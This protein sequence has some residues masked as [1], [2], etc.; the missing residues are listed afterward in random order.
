M[1]Y[2]RKERSSTKTGT[3]ITLS[4]LLVAFVVLKLCGVIDWSWW[5]VT[6]PIWIP[7]GI[8]LLLFAVSGMMILLEKR[9]RKEK[10][11]ED[12]DA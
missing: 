6:S 12:Y 8:A 9:K 2:Y 4:L 7:L 10:R 5:W 11:N 1:R 3:D